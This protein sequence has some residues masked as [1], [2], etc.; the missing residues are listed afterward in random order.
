MNFK[1]TGHHLDITPAI[2]DY[3]KAKLDR[4]LRHSDQILGVQVMLSIDNQKEKDKRQQAGVHVH[5]K[6]K[7]IFVESSHGDL[8]AAIDCLADKL[9][10]QVLK[11]K[12]RVQIHN[13]ESVKHHPVVAD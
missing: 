10:R 12:E 4:A 9:D 3:T 8:Y 1:I 5:L 7:E 2:V 11:H 6:G 13:H